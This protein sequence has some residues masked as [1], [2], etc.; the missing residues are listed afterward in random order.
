ML[1]DSDRAGTLGE[2]D[3]FV[4]FRLHNGAWSEPVSLG[5]AVNTPGSD[6]CPRLTPDGK[7]FLYS[8]KRGDRE[9][10]DI[11]WISTEIIRK[12]RQ[13][14]KIDERLQL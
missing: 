5:P 8:S 3:I 13:K 7:F 2:L 11:Y 1:L 14:L 6:N 10:S 9:S 4:S 12:T